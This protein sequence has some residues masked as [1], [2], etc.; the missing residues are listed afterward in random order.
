MAKP[1]GALDRMIDDIA[2]LQTDLVKLSR[3][4]DTLKERLQRVE[5]QLQRVEAP[6]ACKEPA[7]GPENH[8]PDQPPTFAEEP[9]WME[10]EAAQ[11]TLRSLSAETLKQYGEIWNLVGT[12]GEM[13]TWYCHRYVATRHAG[14][15]LAQATLGLTFS[16]ED[17]P[18]YECH[19]ELRADY[20][21]ISVNQA[22]AIAQDILEFIQ[23]FL[24]EDAADI[25]VRFVE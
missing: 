7:P 19:I 17:G 8:D 22:L 15:D 13:L 24:P 6:T 25:Q 3:E 9:D 20:D 4:N 2:R 14:V 21:T 18:L 16:H 5:D 1:A 23:R 10:D 12:H 11:R